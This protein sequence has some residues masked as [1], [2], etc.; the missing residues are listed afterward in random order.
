M[1][2]GQIRTEEEGSFDVLAGF[3]GGLGEGGLPIE[4]QLLAVRGQHLT[5]VL[6]VH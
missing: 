5:L 3:A 1:G 2:G 6:L 4:G